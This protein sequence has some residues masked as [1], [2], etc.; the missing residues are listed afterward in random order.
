[1]PYA[2]NETAKTTY[3]LTNLNPELAKPTSNIH[4]KQPQTSKSI[5]IYPINPYTKLAEPN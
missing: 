4:Q 1:M 2:D 5:H 3:K